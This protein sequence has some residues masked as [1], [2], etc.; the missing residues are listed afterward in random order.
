MPIFL[1]F[2]LTFEGKKINEA[3][4]LLYQSGKLR[5]FVWLVVF[6][7]GLVQVLV[8]GQI[9]GRGRHHG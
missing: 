1:V 5:P 8:V 6:E 2:F 4:W 7:L 3:W 9:L